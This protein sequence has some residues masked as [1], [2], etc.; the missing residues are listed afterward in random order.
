MSELLA[1]LEQCVGIEDLERAIVA[2]D[3]R[4]DPILGESVWSFTH[5][6]QPYEFVRHGGYLR[7]AVEAG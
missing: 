2:L 1:E 4:H 6:A 5:H 3:D 7:P